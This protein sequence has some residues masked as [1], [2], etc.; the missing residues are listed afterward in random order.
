MTSEGRSSSAAKEELEE[1]LEAGDTAVT[2]PS[3]WDQKRHWDL[4]KGEEHVRYRRRW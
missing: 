4:D 3:G 1:K 2:E